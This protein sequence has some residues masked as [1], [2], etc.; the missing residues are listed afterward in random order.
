M[1]EKALFITL[2]LG[3][4]LIVAL[5]WALASEG[6]P[7]AAAPNAPQSAADW[8][9]I[10]VGAPMVILDGGTYRMWY[11]GRGL[12]FYNP[13]DVGYAESPDGVTW[14]KDASNP[15][16]GPGTPGEWDSYYRGQVAVLED[17]GLYQM[18]YSGGARS[19]PWQVGYA[20][21]NDGLEWTIYAGN[22]VLP[23][24][25]AGS[26]DEV[27][28]DG[29]T[30]IKDGAVYKMWYYG[31]NADY[32]V[33]SIGYATSPDGI[34]WTKYAGNPV[35][36]Q[37]PGEWDESGIAWPRVIK[38]GATYEMW[39]HSDRK[40]GYATSPDGVT[41]TKNA[42]NP[43]LSQGWDG[44]GV[45]VSSLLLDGGTYKL[46]TTSGAGATAGIGYFESAD[47]IE[48]TQPVSNPI[49]V[50]GEG[51]VIIHA[52]YNSDQVRA[53]TTAN[54]PVTITV[55]GPGGVKATISGVTDG[56]GNYYSW[57][58]GGEWDP[59]P[60]QILP[61]DTVSATTP[62]YS[63]IIETVGEV[64]PQ[65]HNDTDVVAGTIHA[66]WFA[67][68]SLS[69]LCRTYDPDQYYLARDV[70]ADGGSF[71]CDF[72]G[73]TDIVGGTGGQAGYLEPDGDMVSVEWTAPYMEVYYG[74][75]DGAG[76]LYAPDHT[77]WITVTNSAG[78]VKATGTVASTA[79]GG[80]WGGQ[81]GFRPTWTG[82]D[83]CD[84]S[85]AE[86]DIQPGD[87]VNFRSDDGYKNQVRAGAIFGTVSVEDDSVTGPI[88][89]SWLTETLEVWCHPDSQ[90]PPSYRQSS[91]EPDGSVPYF[92]EWQDPSGGELWDIQPH[93]QVFVHYVEPDADLV[94]RVMRA[95]DGAPL[96]RVYLPA[97]VK[98]Y[99]P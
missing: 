62:S 76:G 19:G 28:A 72:S 64:K 6:L 35:L 61:G 17:G 44:A 14:A 22:P 34:A 2:V 88:Y 55:S 82:G 58:S 67:P 13:Y 56:G 30:V 24:G 41:W 9:G 45:S 86:P 37:T 47:G 81:D 1:K 42:S 8:D 11:G 54:T 68:G 52:L 84:W 92:C 21:S 57:F 79:D 36:E 12:N 59:E 51:G 5:L 80:W 74:T 4:S 87:W 71:Q 49:L 75:H 25:G 7:A 26:W 33:C 3:L 83:C 98:N 99:S 60:P 90:W 94:Y 95:S 65:A 27:E 89:A 32:S 48:W 93:D 70:P 38:N 50:K 73:L 10:S 15:V 29:P 53:N 77:F 91:A 40:L 31:C 39:Y 20:T 96:P 69:V 46:W 78:D 16:L 63:T 85:P 23:G 66:P 43:V 97:V 18:W